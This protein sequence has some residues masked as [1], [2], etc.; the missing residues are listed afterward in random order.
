MNARGGVVLVLPLLAA[1]CSSPLVRAAK[2]GNAAEVRSLLPGESKRCG[3]ALRAAAAANREEA[4]KVLLAGGCDINSKDKDGYTPLMMAAAKGHDDSVRLLLLRKADPDR[5]T[6]NEKTAAM[7]AREN[8]HKETAQLIEN[9]DRTLNP[10]VAA[11]VAA[12]GAAPSGFL[13]NVI[14]AAAGGAAQGML[15]QAVSGKIPDLNGAAQ[16]AL[17]GTLS[18]GSAGAQGFLNAAA[19]GAAGGALNAAVSGSNRVWKD[20]AAGAVQ[21]AVGALLDSPAEATESPA[22]APE[23]VPRAPTPVEPPVYASP[24][25]VRQLVAANKPPVSTEDELTSI[26]SAQAAAVKKKKQIQSLV[27]Q[28][29][30]LE[31]LIL[32]AAGSLIDRGVEM[33]VVSFDLSEHEQI[34]RRTHGGKVIVVVLSI[35]QLSH[36]SRY[37]Y[38][39]PTGGRGVR[40]NWACEPAACK[41][42]RRGKEARDEQVLDIPDLAVALGPIKRAILREVR[43][44]VEPE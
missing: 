28:E 12:G 13:D 4:L 32:Q 31:N 6:W 34:M 1:G 43:A 41:V 3:E 10:E 14:E 24:T 2:D 30:E 25:P 36:Y 27:R 18:P 11:M 44:S 39:Q 38:L 29:A 35:P 20:S 40:F 7:L 16:G 33:D 5:I 22:P 42:Y 23:N 37:I 17:R 21:G 19:Q 15:Q 26:R 9:L 8:R